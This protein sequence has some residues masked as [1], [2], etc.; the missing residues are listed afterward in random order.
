MSL[1][2]ILDHSVH[3]IF[4]SFIISMN[5]LFADPMCARQRQSTKP[6]HT[7][8]P[9][10]CTVTSST[11]IVLYHVYLNMNAMDRWSISLRLKWT[12]AM[13]LLSTKHYQLPANAENMVDTAL[14]ATRSRQMAAQSVSHDT[15]F[16]TNHS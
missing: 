15:I 5:I 1:S 12:A 6:R 4:S 14:T 11:R 9:G 2:I 10:S 7:A 3:C 13:D 16:W 8:T